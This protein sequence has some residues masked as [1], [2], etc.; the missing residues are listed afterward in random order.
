M[1]LGDEECC[2]LRH[3]AIDGVGAIDIDRF[4]IYLRGGQ[5]VCVVGSERI[6]RQLLRAIGALPPGDNAP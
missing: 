1:S 2:F 6:R 4:L 5:T 3:D